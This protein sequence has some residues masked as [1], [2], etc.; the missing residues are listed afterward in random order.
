[1]IEKI[2][3]IYDFSKIL[4][5]DHK[6]NS[7]SSAQTKIFSADHNFPKSYCFENTRMHQLWW[8]NTDLDFDQL[9]RQL[10][11]KVKTVSS[12]VLPPGSCIPL[13]RD[14]FYKLKNEFPLEEGKMIR[15]VIYI[16]DYDLGQFTQYVDKDSIETFTEW[17]IGQGHIWDDQIPHITANAGYKD[18]ITVNIS[19]FRL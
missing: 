13:H 9:G 15:A 6:Q 18:L 2:S 19:G 1:M 8:N 7:I 11:M 14:T 10:N 3:V 17:N 5:A 12:I 16:T 4:E